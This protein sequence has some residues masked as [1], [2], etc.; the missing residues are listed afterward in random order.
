MSLRRSC[1]GDRL[2]KS[3]IIDHPKQKRTTESKEIAKYNGLAKRSVPGSSK[4]KVGMFA[5]IWISSVF[6]LFVVKQMFI[7]SQAFDDIPEHDSL[8]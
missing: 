4:Y 6:Y 5:L 2:Q 7:P 3:I 1:Y 8:K